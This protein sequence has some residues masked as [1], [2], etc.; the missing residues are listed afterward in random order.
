[1]TGI[2]GYSNANWRYSLFDG[3]TD[4][5]ALERWRTIEQDVASSHTVQV[6]ELLDSMDRNERPFVSGAEARRILEFLASMYKAGFTGET[7]QRGSITLDDPF[8]HSMNGSLQTVE[9]A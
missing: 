3:S 1:V 6:T 4:Q 9:G 5:E 8:Y 2:Y 7:V